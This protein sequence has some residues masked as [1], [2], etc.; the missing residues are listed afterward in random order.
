MVV[1]NLRQLDD[2]LKKSFKKIKR[3][4]K[5]LEESAD[6]LNKDIG[7]IRENLLEV[8]SFKKRLEELEEKFEAVSLVHEVKEETM[9]DEY[10]ED[11][12]FFS[13]IFGR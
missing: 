2:A 11:R 6:N 10:E 12:G 9:V 13:K 4:N 5:R 8:N 3:D 7:V 1:N